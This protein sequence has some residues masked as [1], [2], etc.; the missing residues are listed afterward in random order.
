MFAKRTD[1]A[2]E[3]QELWQESAGKTAALSGV[4]AAVQTRGGYCVHRVEILNDDG[5]KALGKPRGT[6]LTVNLDRDSRQEE[7]FRRAVAAIAD[8]LRELLPPT[9]DVLV[10]ALG[11]ADMTPD[12]IGPLTAENILVTRHL[13]SSM[14][15]QFSSLRGVAVVR[16]G[17][18]GTTGVE[19]AEV[20]QGIAKQISPSAIIAVDALAARRA[21][22]VCA[23]V[24][25]SDSG[26]VPGSGIGN[27]RA[28][29]NRQTLGVP[30]I[31]VGIPTVADAATLAADLLEAHGFGDFDP[32]QLRGGE[33]NMTVTPRDIDAQVRHLSKIT[34]YAINCALQGLDTDDITALL[35]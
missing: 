9:G 28:A 14:P 7:A 12:A 21:R 6:Y 11:N 19:S 17:V 16:A 26:I 31:A 10:A 8:C 3:A 27:H 32:Q 35:G 29:L 30:V 5:E 24:Q 15:E 23:T 25:L 13:I 22:R 33:R 4:K 34:G 20:V 1:L 18:L 2:M